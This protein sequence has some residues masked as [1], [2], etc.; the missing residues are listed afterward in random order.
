MKKMIYVT[1]LFTG[2]IA[3]LLFIAIAVNT[4]NN[5]SS[6]S[7]MTPLVTCM[8]ICTLI[9]NATKKAVNHYANDDYRK[10][11][12]DYLEYRN[13]QELSQMQQMDQINLQNQ[14]AQDAA[15]RA[16]EDARL[17]ATGIEFGGYNPDPNLNPGMQNQMQDFGQ[18]NSFG[19][20]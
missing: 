11:R 18:N 12:A 16:A 1:Y 20:F 13:R 7:E 9:H 6:V 3:I 17:A 2:V 19:M 5:H 8:I 4:M 15:A 10:M 14:Q